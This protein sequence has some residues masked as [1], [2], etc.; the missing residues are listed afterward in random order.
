MTTEEKKTITITMSERRPLK[1]D[2]ELWPVQASA[3]WHDNEHEFQA[4]R[5]RKIIVRE[6]K[7]DGRRIVYGYYT[8]Q[9]QNERGAAGGFL[10]PALEGQPDKPDEEATIRAIRRV[11]G[12][13]DD[14]KLADEC[15][16]DLPAEEVE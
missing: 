5:R 14:D 1:I 7:D 2:P 10:V 9:W 13:I 8:S 3:K 12:I 15:I 16:A 4:N 6:A 11:A